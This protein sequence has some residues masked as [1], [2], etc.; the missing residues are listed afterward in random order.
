MIKSAARHLP[1]AIACAAL[2]MALNERGHRLAREAATRRAPDRL[3]ELLTVLV[4]NMHRSG[5]LKRER[6]ARPCA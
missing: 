1:L 6:G 4:E 3:P 5:V 2:A